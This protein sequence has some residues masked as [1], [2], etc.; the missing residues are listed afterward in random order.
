MAALAVALPIQTAAAGVPQ[1]SKLAEISKAVFG[2]E[3]PTAECIA[4]MESTDG[5][6]L[7]NGD[8]YGPW[9]IE[10]SAHPW[11][12]PWRLI[13]DWWYA[14][15]VTYRLSNGGRDWSAWTTHVLCGV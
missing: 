2:A 10:Q 13:H 14:A 8:Q 6:W 4:H 11:V 5:A 12:N 15:R 7:V 1:P 9:Q 3:A